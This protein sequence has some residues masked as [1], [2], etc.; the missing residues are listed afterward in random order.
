MSHIRF[1][2]MS[3]DARCE[4]REGYRSVTNLYGRF[5]SLASADSREG[6]LEF[7]RALRQEWDDVDIGMS[8]AY[9]A[10]REL[11]TARYAHRNS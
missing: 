11:A 8:S 9:A 2:D 10:G 4:A 5:P 6:S 7:S 1:R 3:H